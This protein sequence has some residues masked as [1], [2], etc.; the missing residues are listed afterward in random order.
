M[1][2]ELAHLNTTFTRGYVK[3][4]LLAVG[5]DW[6]KDLIWLHRRLSDKLNHSAN[7]SILDHLKERLKAVAPSSTIALL[8]SNPLQVIITMIESL[9]NFKLV[10]VGPVFSSVL[11][12]VNC[13]VRVHHGASEIFSGERWETLL[14]EF[15]YDV[16]IGLGSCLD[17]FVVDEFFLHIW[18]SCW[19]RSCNT[20]FLGSTQLRFFTWRYIEFVFDRL[21]LV[22][23][24]GLLLLSFIVGLGVKSDL[25]FLGIHIWNLWNLIILF[26]LF[27]IHFK[28]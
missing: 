8:F 9:N 15:V 23:R 10:R 22:L 24:C 6:V 20:W 7:I 11:L 19:L 4:R 5:F 26:K 3:W 18:N 13:K 28:C 12:E 16:S 21:L 2:E 27:E 17:I 25:P 1:K 14:H